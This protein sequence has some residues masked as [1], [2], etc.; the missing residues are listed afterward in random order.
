M[1]LLITLQ[2]IFSFFCCKGD[3]MKD[4]QN[5]GTPVSDNFYCFLVNANISCVTNAAVIH[6]IY[7]S[8]LLKQS[9]CKEV[10]FVFKKYG[11]SM[12]YYKRYLCEVVKIIP[13]KGNEFPIIINDSLFNKY[14]KSGDY[15]EMLYYYKNAVIYHT[16][17]K[18]FDVNIIPKLPVNKFILNEYDTIILK[19]DFLRSRRDIFSTYRGRIVSISDNDNHIGYVSFGG[20]DS[21]DFLLKDR[22]NNLGLFKQINKPTKEQYT[23]ADTTNYQYEI[24]NRPTVSGYYLS[25]S[26]RFLYLP[27]ATRI[28]EIL[29]EDIK[30]GLGGNFKRTYAKNTI[31][32]GFHVYLYRLDSNLKTI[33]TFNLEKGLDNIYGHHELF[34]EG[35]YIE[36][37]SILYLCHEFDS[38]GQ[39]KGK[40][41]C[42]YSISKLRLNKKL[43]F[44]KTLKIPYSSITDVD[45][46][47]IFAEFDGNILFARSSFGKIYDLR[48]EK[49]CIQLSGLPKNKFKKETYP[50]TIDD[51]SKFNLQYEVLTMQK[52][53]SES[54]VVIYKNFGDVVMEVFNNSFQL[55][56]IEKLEIDDD[57]LEG[58]YFFKNDLLCQLYFK[59]GIPMLIRRKILRKSI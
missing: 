22:A 7:N 9:V 47:C 17:T 36:G 44:L 48:S 56:Q 55:I 57:N 33:D 43:T 19:S 45:V 26:D 29:K 39:Y 41:Y 20:S 3:L 40:S 23:V 8:Y 38:E 27:I 58:G 37:D 53:D 30:L 50:K 1:K 59:D 49:L 31:M 52:I 5:A 4:I 34:F 2:F 51:T 24:I 32:G 14:N 25:P 10:V 35:V 46:R 18:F 21:L 13:A 28:N 12:D 6:S 16:V 11:Y 42:Q 54:F 15:S